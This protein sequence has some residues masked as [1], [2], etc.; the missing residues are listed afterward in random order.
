MTVEGTSIQY[1]W[2]NLR[3]TVFRT[4]K[5]DENLIRAEN[6]AGGSPGATELKWFSRS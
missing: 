1:F 5:V 4:I 6:F 2:L 3:E